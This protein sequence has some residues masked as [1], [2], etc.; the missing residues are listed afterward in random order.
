MFLLIF[1]SFCN[2]ISSLESEQLISIMFFILLKI[3]MHLLHL[4]DT[5]ASLWFQSK[6]KIYL[7]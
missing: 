3:K 6:G 2:I 4:A 1:L 5:Y 7:R